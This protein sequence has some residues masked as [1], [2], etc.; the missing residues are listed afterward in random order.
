[1]ASTTSEFKDGGKKL[2]NHKIP[3][4]RV[5]GLDQPADKAAE[6]LLF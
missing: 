4:Q 5:K 3:K 2:G 6:F 1:M